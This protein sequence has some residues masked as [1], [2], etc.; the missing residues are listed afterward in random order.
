MAVMFPVAEKELLTRLRSGDR[1]AF[2]QLYYT[3]NDR[4]YGRLLKLT[5][6][7]YL[8]DELLQDTFVKLW[9]NRD[10]INPDLSIKAWLYKVA[11]NEV[12]LFYRKVARDRRLQEHIVA[13]FAESYSHTEEDIYL[14]ESRELLDKAI[15][16]LTP[17]RKEVFTLCKIEGRSYEEVAQLLGISPNTVSSHLVKATSSVRKF[18]FQSKEGVALTISMVLFKSL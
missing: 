6:T 13:T 12:F 3:Y 7:E 16:Q 17:Q 1:K 2:E 10:Q 14:K 5:A 8:A 15:D 9:D 11:Q 18:L 4:I